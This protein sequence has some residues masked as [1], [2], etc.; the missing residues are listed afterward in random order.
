MVQPIVAG[1][2]A[3]LTGFASSF[4]IVIAGLLGVGATPAEAASGLLALCVLQ[5]LLAIVLSWT[6]RL[7]LAFAWSTPGA[8]L[9]VAAQGS[10]SS[11]GAAVGAFLV[12]G[13]L[14]ILTG[15]WPALGRAMTSI[16]APVSGAMLAGILFPL[17]IAPVTATIEAPLFAIPIV[18]VWLILQRLAPRWAVPAA[19]VIAIVGVAVMSGGSPLGSSNWAPGL[20]FVLPVLDPL[21]IVSLGI[22][23]YIVTMVGQNVPG[24]AVLGTLGYTNLPTRSMLVGSGIATTLAAPFGGHSVNL[25]A[26]SAAITGGPDAHPDPGRRWIATLSG[27]VSYLAL[28]LVAGAAGAFIDHASP[29]LIV[30]VAGLALIGAFTTGV[31]SAFA[32]PE[33]RLA[34]AVTFVV[35]A[36]GIAVAGIGSAF[37]GLLAGLGVYLLF[38]ARKKDG[39]PRTAE[40]GST[41]DEEE[42]REHRR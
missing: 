27:G 31:V 24:F 18:L 12:C 14:V 30:A 2:V 8:A 1:I 38:R 6:S 11:F 34:A 7:P 20:H 32:D 10:T 25:A 23:L 26:L 9:L 33:H 17:C 22:P 29:V 41:A 40:D 28:G 19:I 21:T 5:G 4:A 42:P 3:A 15:L 39:N 35:V 16:P 36:S 37:W 13:I